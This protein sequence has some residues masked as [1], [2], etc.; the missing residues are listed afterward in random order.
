L[1]DLNGTLIE[2]QFYGEELTV[3]RVPKRTTYK[4]GKTL[5]KRYRNGILQ[6][7]VS[8]K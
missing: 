1:E 8:S 7:L 5:D 3:V 6:Y 2:G 4:T